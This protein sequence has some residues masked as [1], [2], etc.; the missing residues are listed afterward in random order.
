MRLF[1]FRMSQSAQNVGL[2]VIDTP[3]AVCRLPPDAPVPAWAAGGPFSSVTRTADEL[4]VVCAA[5]AV[6]AE[7]P[8][9]CITSRDWRALRV[10]GPLDLALVG[11]LAALATPLAEAGVSIFPIATHDTDWILVPGAQL[12]RACDALARAGHEVRGREV[13]GREVRGR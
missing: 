12:D 6:P 3:L 5:A 13:R 7:L 1:P 2:Y 11:V 4:S 10:D 9:P 8:A